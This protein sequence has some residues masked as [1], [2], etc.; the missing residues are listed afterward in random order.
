[1]KKYVIFKS[2]LDDE[3]PL[4]R[5]ILNE[6]SGF[7][8]CRCGCEGCFEPDDYQIIKKQFVASMLGELIAFIGKTIEKLKRFF[9]CLRRIRP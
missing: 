6:D 4:Q 8:D 7:V 9:F 3:E 5:G 1:M 2:L